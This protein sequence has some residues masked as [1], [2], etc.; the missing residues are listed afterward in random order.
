MSV[1]VELFF[2]LMDRRPP[3]STRTDTL[4]PYTTLFRSN[5]ER[6]GA[7]SE[8]ATWHTSAPDKAALIA[9]IRVRAPAWSRANGRPAKQPGM[10]RFGDI[11][12]RQLTGTSMRVADVGCPPCDTWNAR[13]G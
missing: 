1:L 13:S 7:R 8:C 11:P 10:A 5:Q 2:F 3:R 6:P 4:F 9:A 12:A